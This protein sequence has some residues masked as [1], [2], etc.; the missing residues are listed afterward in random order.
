MPVLDLA[1]PREVSIREKFVYGQRLARVRRRA[2]MSQRV[3]AKAI[4]CTQGFISRV[5][6]GQMMLQAADYPVVAQFLGA[7]VDELLG[8]F[9]AE[10]REL[11]SATPE[12]WLEARR[13]AGC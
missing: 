6:D 11:L 12:Q 3:L 1:M 13:K 5:E 7:S 10:E 4:D 9:T 8:P 2:G